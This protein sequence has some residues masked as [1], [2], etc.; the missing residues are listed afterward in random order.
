MITT[1]DFN[2]GLTIKLDGKL[3]KIMNYDHV[4]PGKGGAFLQT[5][6]KNLETGQTINKRFRAG[7]KVEKAH[8][9]HRKFQFLYSS[10]EEYTF[11]DTETYEQVEISAEDIGE[12]IKFIKE[13]DEVEIE[14]YQGN[15][16]GVNLPA[17]V[18]L[19]VTM[20]PPAVKGNTVSGATK[21]VTVETGT[22]V[23]VPLFIE[24]N[25]MIKIDTRTGEYIERV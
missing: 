8:I 13:N 18:E 10:D 23:D 17:A 25:E 22:K 3:Y 6:L 5:E 1:R 9:D 24:K 16:V 7:E 15:P 20:A 4:K 14:M 19:E 11:M 12:A 2:T 21:E